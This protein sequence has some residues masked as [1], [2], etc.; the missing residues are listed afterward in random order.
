MI[1]EKII[2]TK[3]F[4]DSYMDETCSGCIVKVDDSSFDDI[5]QPYVETVGIDNKID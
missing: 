2:I 3:T 1:E 5:N 4:N